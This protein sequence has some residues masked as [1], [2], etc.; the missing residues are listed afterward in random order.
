MKLN[1]E[2]KINKYLKVVKNKIKIK[3]LIQEIRIRQVTQ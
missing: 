2:L 1:L 3:C